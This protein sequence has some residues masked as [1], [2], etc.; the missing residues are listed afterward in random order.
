LRAAHHLLGIGW[1]SDALMGSEVVQT[2]LAILWTLIAL[3]LMVIA[4]RRAERT[5]WLAGAA[6]LGL[7]VLK[8]LLV[9]LDAAGGGARIITFIAVG[10]MMLVVGYAAP[11]PPKP[12]R[13]GEPA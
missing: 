6:L 5:P 2:G 4:Q 3:G 8:L 9:D 1:S 13:S 7:T 10:V 11:L 12:L